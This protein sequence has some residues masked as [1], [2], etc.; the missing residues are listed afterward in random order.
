MYKY[1]YKCRGLSNFFFN[2]NRNW[3]TNKTNINWM[4]WFECCYLSFLQW[5]KQYIKWTHF[6]PTAI[7]FNQNAL[8]LA[9]SMRMLFFC[10]LK[11]SEKWIDMFY[12]DVKG[13][14]TLRILGFTRLCSLSSGMHHFRLLWIFVFLP[15]HKDVTW[16][17]IIACLVL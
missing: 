3:M 5:L 15:F 12:E 10:N 1:Q 14:S 9:E 7:E 8:V 16:I 11:I 17:S 2:P 4:S 6:L 13:C